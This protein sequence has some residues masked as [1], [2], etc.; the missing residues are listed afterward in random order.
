MQYCAMAK[1][2]VAVSIRCSLVC[3][4][5][6]GSSISCSIANTDG[7]CG[8]GSSCRF[9][10]SPE[11][12]LLVQG[13]CDLA[14]HVTEK[15]VE[16][17]RKDFLGLFCKLDFEKKTATAVSPRDI[18]GV[19]TAPL[20]WANPTAYCGIDCTFKYMPRTNQIMK[21]GTCQSSLDSLSEVCID[22][23]DIE[24]CN[25]SYDVVTGWAAEPMNSG[26]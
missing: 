3:G 12:D 20:P 10:K 23:Q 26:F 24:Y 21:S 5:H 16:C 8:L 2:L 13:P 22:D 19:A 1:V 9:A 17:W 14:Y 18:C 7:S 11:G 4:V 15:S 25:V 6:L